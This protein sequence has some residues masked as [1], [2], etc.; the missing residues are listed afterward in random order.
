MDNYPHSHHDAKMDHDPQAPFYG[1]HLGYAVLGV[2][3]F[4]L[5]RWF[6]ESWIVI[7]FLFVNPCIS[8][9]VIHCIRMDKQLRMRR[10]I[11]LA[12]SNQ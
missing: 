10:K 6:F 12:K 8:L 7:F 3:Y 4:I 1:C 2:S 11:D 5:I 9:W